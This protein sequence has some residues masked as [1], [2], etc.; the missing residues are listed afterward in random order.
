[1][2]D[3][4]ITSK[5][6]VKLLLKFF[7]NSN[8]SSYLRSLEQEFGESTNA[9]RLELNRFEK[10][11]LL[12]SF[13]KGNKKMFKANTKHPLF[14]NIHNL[15]LTHIGF[16]HIIDKVI[17]KLGD[18]KMVFIIGDFAKGRD[19]KIIDLIFVGTNIDKEYL[20][21][22]IGRAENII[23]RKIRFLVYRDEDYKDILNDYKESEILLLWKE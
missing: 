20:V 18:V 16:D 10:A 4:L 21:R 23:K 5:T 13:I 22:Q 19:S 6:R 2:L 9:I 3:T 8:S 11:G 17:R 12:S 14:G 15:L 7:L 1:V